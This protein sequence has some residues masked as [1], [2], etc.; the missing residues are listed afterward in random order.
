MYN[1][2]LH[3]HFTG[4]GGSGMSGLAEILL[5]LGFKVSGSDLKRSSTS[6][7]LQRLGAI[8]SLGHAADNLPASAS[9]LVYS[10][11][12]SPNNPE[13]LEAKQ[14]GLP[15]IPR[16]EVLAELMRLKYGVAVAGS[17][18]K[19]TTTSMTAAIL[20]AAKLDPTVVIGGQVKSIG[21]G[22]KL[23]KG[24]FL[25]AET[26]E[27]DRSFLLLKP[28][29]AIVT[30]IDAEH[31]VAY[32]SQADLDASFEQFVR[33]VPFYGLAVLCVDDHKVADIAARYT[34]RKVTYG[35][36]PSADIRAENLEFTPEMTCFDVI[37]HAD[38]LMRVELPMLGR[39]IAL[40]SLAAIAVGLELGV[41]PQTIA[42]ALAGFSGVHRRLEVVG[43]A[44]GVT[45]MNDYGHH[46]TEVRATLAAV[47][48]AY[49]GKVSRFTVIF[50]PHRYTR[51]RDCFVDFLDAFSDC[52]RLLM[53][54]IYAAS[55]EPIEGI[56]TQRLLEAMSHP[57]REFAADL[58]AALDRVLA[59]AQPGELVLCL[60]AGS[61]GGLPERLVSSLE[62]RVAA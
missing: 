7:R 61:I 62:G 3:F 55:E 43:V 12:V 32:S 30:N 15:V 10:S 52:D 50:Q 47:K 24:Q 13:L 44:G 58:D 45:V 40:N 26:D 20:E 57:Q 8:V 18:G 42:A 33:A 25:V 17:H 38:K 48:S 51:T 28:T 1:P 6:D 19:T 53:T 23:G 2:N 39:H 49:A 41:A 35:L 4:I 27:S 56:D 16:A 34:G 46:P 37:R 14:R 31:L 22:G 60:G 9:L 5:T 59:S 29:I 36:S 11:A 54:P 21:S